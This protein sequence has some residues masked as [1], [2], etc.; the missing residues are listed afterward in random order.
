MG[1]N[2]SAGL[3]STITRVLPEVADGIGGYAGAELA[4]GIAK[5]T[6]EEEPAPP[7]TLRRSLGL[8]DC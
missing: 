4:D 1:E 2:P 5:L 8:G 7:L 6:P 3:W